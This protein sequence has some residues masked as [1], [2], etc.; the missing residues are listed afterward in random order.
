MNEMEQIQRGLEAFLE[1]ELAG[2]Q[3]E[4]SGPQLYHVQ[5]EE[6]ALEW[7]DNK[8]SDDMEDWEVA[9]ISEEQTYFDVCYNFVTYQKKK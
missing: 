1:R 8:E 5:E 4:K 9:D 6:K 3:T 2:M 7:E